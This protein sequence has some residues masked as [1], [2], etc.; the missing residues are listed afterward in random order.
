VR[1]N[2]V[3]HCNEAGLDSNRAIDSLFADNILVN[4]S[5]VLLRGGSQARVERNQLDG[6]IT[7]RDTSSAQASDNAV[8]DTRELFEDADR[9]QLQRR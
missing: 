9:L 1:N 8:G 4:T 6:A 2:V 7:T 3:A 5:G